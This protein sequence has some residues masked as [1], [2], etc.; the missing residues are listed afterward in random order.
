VSPGLRR[1]Q[2]FR[3]VFWYCRVAYSLYFCAVVFGAVSHPSKAVKF[4]I[5]FGLLG[6]FL[7]DGLALWQYG[8]LKKNEK[9]V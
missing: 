3:S 9:V 7:L 2:R 1:I 8:R 4:I 6:F 5:F